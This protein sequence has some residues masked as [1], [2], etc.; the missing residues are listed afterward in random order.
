MTEETGTITGTL[1]AQVAAQNIAAQAIAAAQEQTTATRVARAVQAL[2]EP[3]TPGMV[4]IAGGA[5]AY[6][7]LLEEHEKLKQEF[8][9]VTRERD[10]LSRILADYETNLEYVPRRD[11][12]DDKRKGGR[13]Y[14]DVERQ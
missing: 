8:E 11:R 1:L 3:T 12:N 9:K 6:M 5:P 2:R 13:F 10:G 14:S 4:V 7:R